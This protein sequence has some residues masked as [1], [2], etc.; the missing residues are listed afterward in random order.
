LSWNDHPRLAY[1]TY[2]FNKYVKKFGIPVAAATAIL[3]TMILAFPAALGVLALKLPSGFGDAFDAPI[4]NTYRPE[5][6][7]H[8][9]AVRTTSQAQGGLTTTQ[10]SIMKTVLD[11]L[12]TEHLKG[13]NFI[14]SL[15]TKLVTVSGQSG[16]TAAGEADEAGAIVLDTSKILTDSFFQEC[17]LHEIG[18]I[19]QFQSLGFYDK[20]WEKISK[21]STDRG[22][23]VSDYAQTNDKEDF[24]ESYEHWT[25]SSA[26]MALDA[27]IAAKNGNPGLLKKYLFMAGLFMNKDKKSLATYTG[28]NFSMDEVSSEEPGMGEE[29]DQPSEGIYSKLV[30]VTQSI[31]FFR[32]DLPYYRTADSLTIN[33]YT[34]RLNGNRITS[35]EDFWGETIVDGLNI[36]IPSIFADSMQLTGPP[37]PPPP[38]P[39]QWQLIV[40]PTCPE[41]EVCTDPTGSDPMGAMKSPMLVSPKLPT[42]YIP[43]HSNS[44]FKAI[45]G[46]Q[47]VAH[48]KH[49]MTV[50]DEIRPHGHFGSAQ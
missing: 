37:P 21:Q 11:A 45:A 46:E 30:Q 18:H 29:P 7:N 3:P 41:G 33:A 35:I 38:K 28:G 32:T 31:E 23:F 42:A 8:D 5:H 25:K 2:R 49:E 19:V 20:E 4:H 16:V 27:T 10:K 1:L 22:D 39:V 14:G 13:V 6:L 47:A 36:E 15:S 40:T 17:L 50:Q 43:L 26:M 34:Y 9:I 44:G 12:P 24:A 48:P